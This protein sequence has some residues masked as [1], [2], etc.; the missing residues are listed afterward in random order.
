MYALLTDYTVYTLVTV[1][2][3]PISANFQSL[4]LTTSSFT[5]D[6]SY[7]TCFI[8]FKKAP[9]CYIVA[10]P[11]NLL[12]TSKDTFCPCL[13]PCFFSTNYFYI[14]VAVASCLV[15]QSFSFSTYFSS[16]FESSPTLLGRLGLYTRSRRV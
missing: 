8:I 2:N 7:D 11:C 3:I 4:L 5:V 10:V 14:V 13:T 1:L 6:L 15:F 16:L 9:I 12:Y